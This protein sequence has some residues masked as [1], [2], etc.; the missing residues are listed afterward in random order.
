MRVEDPPAVPDD[1]EA[2]AQKF[3]DVAMPV[4]SSIAAL[5]DV[6]LASFPDHEDAIISGAMTSL[7]RFGIERQNAAREQWLP[8]TQGRSPTL[9]VRDVLGY[10]AKFIQSSA[11]ILLNKPASHDA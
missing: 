8:T 6:F 1:E 5:L 9:T 4:D 10:F 11:E 7:V 2:K 3:A